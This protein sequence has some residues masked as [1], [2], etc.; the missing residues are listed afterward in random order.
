[1]SSRNSHPFTREGVIARLKELN[2]AKVDAKQFGLQFKADR[3]EMRALLTQ[4]VDEKVV[5]IHRMA[6][7]TRYSIPEDGVMSDDYAAKLEKLLSEKLTARPFRPLQGYEANL[8]KL[9]IRREI[10]PL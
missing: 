10:E 3:G 4:L 1:M 8:R 5:M 2:G 6:K 7:V 9:M